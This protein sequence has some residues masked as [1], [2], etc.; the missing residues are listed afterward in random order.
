MI[1]RP[2]CARAPPGVLIFLSFLWA[3]IKHCYKTLY[4]GYTRDCSQFMSKVAS[5][6]SASSTLPSIFYLMLCFRFSISKHFNNA[7]MLPAH[8]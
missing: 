1:N 8:M 2:A 7:N 6:K 5:Y 3:K 4:M